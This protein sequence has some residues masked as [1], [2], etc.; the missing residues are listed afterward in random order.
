LNPLPA[1]PKVKGDPAQFGRLVDTS[2]FYE[3]AKKGRL[4]QV[5]WII[6]SS[7]VSGHPPSSIKEGM[8]YV[9]GLVNAIMESPEWNT[10]AVFI[11]WDDWGGFYDHVAPPK[12]D[13]YG[14]GIRVPGI[15]I[16]PYV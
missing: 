13:E 14:Y 11:S 4:P 1:F 7:K 5:S 16:S 6:P 12:V 10:T 15:V 8:A 9:T 3:D 2:Q